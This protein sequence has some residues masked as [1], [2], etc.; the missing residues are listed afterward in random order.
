MRRLLTNLGDAN[1]SAS[2]VR[3][4]TLNS[5]TLNS[6]KHHLFSTSLAELN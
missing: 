6:I 3:W 5:G 1:T 4:L 2:V